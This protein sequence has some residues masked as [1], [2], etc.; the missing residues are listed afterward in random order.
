MM[1]SI[2]FDQMTMIGGREATIRPLDP[3]LLNRA[4]SKGQYPFPSVFLVSI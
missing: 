2:V 1:D 3:S 4:S